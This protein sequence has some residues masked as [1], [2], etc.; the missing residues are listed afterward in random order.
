[1]LR[2]LLGLLAM[3]GAFSAWSA[4]SPAP[5]LNE[6]VRV[7]LGQ[8]V[9][10]SSPAIHRSSATTDR[11]HASG[12]SMVEVRKGETLVRIVRAHFKGS[13]FRDDFIFKAFVALNP[14]AF[15][16]KTHHVVSAGAR[17]QVPTHADLMGMAEGMTPAAGETPSSVG[18]SANPSSAQRKHWVRFP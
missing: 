17:L 15:P 18:A 12:R 8:T 10:Q 3:M 5:A 11:V 16:R 4:E 1:M 2:Y 7:F 6:A 13:P 9:T 14:E